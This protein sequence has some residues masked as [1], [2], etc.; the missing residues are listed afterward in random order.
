[1]EARF[2]GFQPV[3]GRSVGQRG[4]VDRLIFDRGD[5]SKSALAPTLVICAFDPDDL[6]LRYTASERNSFGNGEKFTV[7]DSLKLTHLLG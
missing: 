5:S 7:S 6:G 3:A 1:M 4:A 2:I